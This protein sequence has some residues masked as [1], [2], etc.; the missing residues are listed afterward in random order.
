MSNFLHDLRFGLRMVLKQPAVSA[1]AIVALALGIGLTTTMYS[2]VH[3][4][5]GDL[6]FDEAHEIY[7]LQQ[8]NPSRDIEEIALDGYDFL[9]WREQQTAFEDLAAFYQG[10]INVAGTESP[11]RYEGA[12]M[13]AETFTLLGIEA[14]LGRVFSPAD[15][16]PGAEPVLL[17]G[18]EVWQNHH[19]ADPGVIGLDVRINGQPGTIIGVMPEGFAFP[20][21]EEAW[22]P[23]VIDTTTVARGEGRRHNVLG[24]LRDGVDPEMALAE[25]QTISERLETEYPELNEGVRAN[26]MPYVR[27][28]IDGQTIAMLWTMQGA[29]FMVLLIACA[30]VAN[31]LLSRALDRSREV[32]VRSA[33]GASR[34]RVVGQMLTEALVMAAIGGLLGLGIARIGVTWFN[35]ALMTTEVPFWISVSL[36]WQVMLFA[37]A[38]V[39]AAAIL[40]GVMPAWQITGT[41]LSD[42]LKD[43]S[44]G[45]SSFRMGR[46]SKVL[47]VAE[48][49]FSCGLL[50]GAG[51]MIKSVTQLQTLDY[52]FPTDVLTARAGLFDTDYPDVEHRR[53]FFEELHRRIGAQP[54]VDQVALAD[55]LPGTYRA[56]M[57]RFGLDGEAYATR[58][59]YPRANFAVVTPGFFS[60]FD[61]E[62]IQGR[63]FSGDD[64]ADGLQVT[65]VNVSFVEQFFAGTN[66]IGQRFRPGLDDEDN[67]NPW[68][69]I[70]GVVPD[71]SMEGVGDTGDRPPEG[72]YLPLSQSDRQFMS[73]AARG[74]GDSQDLAG[75]VREA[76][77]SLDA[78]L[79][80]YW[81]RP[82]QEEIDSNTWFYNVFGKLFMVF[83][84]AALFL[85]SIGLYGV[86]SFAVGRRTQEVGIRMA[87]G[88]QARDVLGLV[89]K[90]GLWQVGVGMVFGL[91]L[92]VLASGGLELVLFEVD[93]RDMTVYALVFA[94]LA[95]TGLLACLL[96]AARA[97]RINPIEALRP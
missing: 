16:E 23:L 40:A 77:A 85:A 19:R 51:L 68:L 46:I 62:L 28:Y 33:M 18:Y 89:I 70:I 45:S 38:T 66:P 93:P 21:A 50:V 47:V 34:A 6:P 96:P 39:F 95:A 22:T 79:P 80:L 27:D 67:E 1:I 24:R 52:G 88:A 4:A 37:A 35:G 75:L 29:V 91:A 81:V 12:F 73:I 20:M 65:I 2:I 31:L 97:S 58:D 9:D 15:S 59:D 5:L 61:A 60:T 17:I 56:S 30:N 55:A 87:L 54:G 42:I 76:T 7:S 36:D 10:T 72:F 90:Q 69:T 63:D 13:S 3:G 48:V 53:E 78:N 71:L 26:M 11:V 43:E 74:R 83:G 57:N 82:L 86:M 64:R 32:A 49:A 84:G 94:A 25:L 44:R 41:N 14:H 92:A 8:T